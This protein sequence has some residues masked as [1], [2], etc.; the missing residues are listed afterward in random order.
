M[1]IKTLIAV[2]S[3]VFSVLPTVAA[4]SQEE[5]PDVWKP[6][7]FFIGQWE[8]QGEGKPGVSRGRQE[9][10]FVLAGQFL[11]VRNEAVFDPQEQNPKGERHEDWGFFSFDRTRKAYV[12]RQFHV[13]GFVNQYVCAG[14]AAD[15]KTFVFLSEAI[16]NLPPGFQARLTYK[17][18]DEASFEQTFDLAPPGQ[19]MACYSKGVMIRKGSRPPAREVRRKAALTSPAF[20]VQIAVDAESP[21][22]PDGRHSLAELSFKV[23]FA[24]VTFEFDANE[25]PLLGR[26][27]VNAGKGKGAFSRLALNEV[28]SGEERAPALFL[29]ERPREFGAGLAI[30]AEPTAEDEAAA[31]SK[32][33][34]AKV[35]LSFWTDLGP[36]PITWGSKFG[37]ARL[38]DFKVVFEVPFRRLIE[39]RPF[40]VTLPY[41]GRY[42]E[43][44]GS[45]RIDFRPKPKAVGRP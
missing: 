22:V 45:W 13:E 29:S 23:D 37:S 26:C 18:L 42:A 34:P 38:S 32:A 25:D 7:R 33:P 3:I 11:Q 19:E 41:Q 44:K 1:K 20:I 16:E 10:S 28:Q 12:L 30:E 5:L 39:G 35:Q 21:F 17:I 8:G 40:S 2:S 31:A 43:D 9:Y 14:P 6:F 15:G 27:Q 24:S 36:A 4:Q